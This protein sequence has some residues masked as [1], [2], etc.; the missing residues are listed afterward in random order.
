M[1]NKVLIELQY[2]PPIS[3]FVM[4]IRGEKFILESK[5]NYRKGSYRNRCY[6]AGANGR[7][8]LS[9][10]LAGG[11]HQQQAIK[12]VNIS[13]QEDWQKQHWRSIR[14]AYGKAPF[15]IH[16]E[17]EI[18]QLFSQKTI[19]LFDWNLLTLMQCLQLLN[20]NVDIEFSEEF[21][22][23]TKKGVR[24]LRNQINPKEKPGEERKQL[25]YPQVFQEKNGFLPNLSI[26]DLIFCQ[27]P[28]ASVLLRKHAKELNNDYSD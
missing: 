3:F 26:L 19:T 15:F 2:F 11:K 1:L 12:E 10:P 22:T 18:K 7:Q 6:I 23:E 24:D 8:M 17:E 28:Q 4:A 13:Y 21:Q 20:L 16:Y 14:S 25:L 27:G 5:E 9:I